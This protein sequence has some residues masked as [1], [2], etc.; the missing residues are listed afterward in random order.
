VNSIATVVSVELRR[1]EP[2]LPHGN[3]GSPA[4]A[5]AEGKSHRVARAQA[6]TLAAG[7]FITAAAYSLDFLPAEWGIVDAMPRTFN[8]VTAP[9]GGLFLVGMLLPFVGGRAAFAATC[10]GIG[11]SVALGYSKQIGQQLAAWQW[12]EQA[13]PSVSFTWIMPTALLVTMLSAV[14]FSLL[15]KASAVPSN[16]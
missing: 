8:A 4:S 5:A 7:S 6:I 1:R 2:P 15:Q 3:G 10:C 12:I 9:L 13:P 11:T 14:I 16:P